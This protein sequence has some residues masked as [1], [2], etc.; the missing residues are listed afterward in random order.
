MTAT[1]LKAKIDD[2]LQ[3][4]GHPQSTN[5]NDDSALSQIQ[6]SLDDSF[7]LAKEG[8]DE[9][10]GGQEEQKIGTGVTLAGRLSRWVKNRAGRKT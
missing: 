9:L 1:D 5:P 2:Q 6:D 4:A 7:R 8:A 3:K 10:L